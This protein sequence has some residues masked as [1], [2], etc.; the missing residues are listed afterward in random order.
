MTGAKI[1]S[2]CGTNIAWID[3]SSKVLAKAE[4]AEKDYRWTKRLITEVYNY[5]RSNQQREVVANLFVGEWTKYLEDIEEDVR[6]RFR[7]G[8]GYVPREDVG[9]KRVLEIYFID[10][11]QGDS[12]LIQTADDKRVLIDGGADNSAH[13]FLLWKYNLKKYHK[14][15]DAVIMTHG[16]WDHSGGLIRILKDNHVL[17]KAIYHNGIAKR[18]DGSLG[19]VT[20]TEEGDVVVDLYDDIE[21]LKP[22][23]SEL[24]SIYQGWFDAVTKAKR[25]AER[26]KLDFKCVRADQNTE[27]ISIGG[28]EGLRIRFLGPINLGDEESPCLKTFGDQWIAS[29]TINGNSV[30]VLLEYGQARILLCGDMN[31]PAE[32]FFLR[33]HRGEKALR[34]HVFKANHHGSKDFS[35]NFLRAV[36]PWVTVVSSGDF[37]DYG[38]PRACLLGSLGHYAPPEIEKPLLFSTE[39]AATFHPIPV[40]KLRE[41]GPYVY[42]KNIHGMIHVR[43]DGNWLA[44]GRVYGR[45][46][47]KGKEGRPTKSLWKWEA[48]AFNLKNAKT[49]EN[50][51]LGS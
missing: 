2:K 17:V 35:S 7:G 41:K 40:Y 16:D 42:E 48:Y 34:A 37:P 25:R 49:L 32:K 36:K 22:Q 21:D 27:K 19:E 11:G 28:E 3:M 51:L 4:E 15:F 50:K 12:I 45:R 18:R 29:K 43:T 38:H 14:I 46:K 1:N 26:H 39:I 47:K 9:N 23:Y 44:A 31:E 10:V 20:Q 8:E 6:I 33:R 30:S 5:P 24:T 13:S